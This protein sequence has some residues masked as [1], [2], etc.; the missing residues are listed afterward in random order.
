MDRR[1]FMPGTAIGALMLSAKGLAFAQE[2]KDSAPDLNQF[3]RN[4]TVIVHNPEGVIRNPGWFNPWVAGAGAGTSN[5][6]HQ[7][8]TDTLWFIDPDAGIE[9]ASDNA[10]YNLLADGPWE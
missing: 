4:E 6:P 2:S 3:P 1:S 5:G 8:I 7:L 10:V 9:G